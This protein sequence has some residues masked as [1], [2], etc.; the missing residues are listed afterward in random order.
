MIGVIAEGIAVIMNEFAEVFYFKR[1]VE[2]A[3]GF[4]IGFHPEFILP[5]I[6]S[7]NLRRIIFIS[8]EEAV[9]IAV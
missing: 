7:C 4:K 5:I 6:V 1:V 3:G 2:K 8:I 9:D